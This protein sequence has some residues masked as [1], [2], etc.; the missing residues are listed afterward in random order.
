MI[1]KVSASMLEHQQPLDSP[2]EARGSDSAD[3][4]G[5][6]MT[7]AEPG[8]LLLQSPSESALQDA[9]RGEI[10]LSLPGPGDTRARREYTLLWLTPAEWLLECPAAQIDSLQTGLTRRLATSLAIV[11]DMT[12]AFAC[13]ELSG[14]R[15]EE[16]LMSGC[17]LDLRADNFPAGRVAR[18]SL[19][20]VPAIIRKTAEP[21]GFR[22][23]V[24]RGYARHV[25]DWLLMITG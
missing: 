25:R 16:V 8:L 9:L 11:T 1:Q 12:E 20:A 7:L 15:T 23:L 14:T 13:F 3:E 10:S 18:T 6:R 17:S 5:F 22:C 21:R 4:P 19:A 24:D 2:P